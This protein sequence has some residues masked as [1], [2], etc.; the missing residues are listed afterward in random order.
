MSGGD[1]AGA[2]AAAGNGSG[3][4]DRARMNK[5][6]D[7][8]W[9]KSDAAKIVIDSVSRRTKD[10]STVTSQ[11]T[12]MGDYME[13]RR[14][15]PFGPQEQNLLIAGEEREYLVGHVTV[16]DVL[17]GSLTVADTGSMFPYTTHASTINRFYEE[18]KDNAKMA[19]RLRDEPVDGTP[20]ISEDEVTARIKAVN[21]PLHEGDTKRCYNS[22]IRFVTPYSRKRSSR[23]RR[24]SWWPTPMIGKST[25]TI[26]LGQQIKPGS[27][28]CHALPTGA[29]AG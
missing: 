27:S 14:S 3:R 7:G 24:H 20:P 12:V 16:D 21:K 26:G 29:N 28:Q 15:A 23:H 11:L 2:A 25:Y 17:R 9:A 22:Y 19:R 6:H 8:L 10:L 5:V 1:I 18:H 4:Y 13:V